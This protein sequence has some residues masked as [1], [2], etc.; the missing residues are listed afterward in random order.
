[1]SG[2]AVEVLGMLSLHDIRDSLDL[3]FEL[4]KQF[5]QNRSGPTWRVAACHYD[6]MGRA[7]AVSYTVGGSTGVGAS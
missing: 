4:S 1:M 6:L 5:L 2:M 3:Y 7:K